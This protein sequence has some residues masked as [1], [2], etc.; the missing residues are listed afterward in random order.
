MGFYFFLSGEKQKR[1]LFTRMSTEKGTGQDMPLTQVPCMGTQGARV[2]KTSF[3]FTL[4]AGE[5]PEN[6]EW[7]RGLKLLKLKEA[8][9]LV[10]LSL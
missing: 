4:K 2:G 9:Q 6:A 1:W 3:P 8:A 7:L 5:G 10:Q